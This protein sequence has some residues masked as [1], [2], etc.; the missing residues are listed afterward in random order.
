MHAESN[1]QR[2]SVVGQPAYRTHTPSTGPLLSHSRQSPQPA[3]HDRY[4][5]TS[6]RETLLSHS[7]NGWARDGVTFVALPF[8]V[9]RAEAEYLWS[10]D[11]G[12]PSAPL[13]VE[14]YA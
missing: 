8:G 14:E 1:R 3:F 5:V 11:V 12:S 10:V 2:T 9:Y 7:L 13:F 4:I 6:E